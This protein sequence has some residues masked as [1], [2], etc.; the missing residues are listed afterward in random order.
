MAQAFK[1][2]RAAHTPQGALAW[3]V[4]LLTVPFLALPAHALFGQSRHARAVLARRRSDERAAEDLVPLVEGG[5]PSSRAP[6]GE[7]GEL[8]ALSTLAGVPALKGNGAALLVDGA[9]SFEAIF[10]AVEEARDYVLLSFYILRD[11]ALG[12]EFR[13]RLV[14]RAAAGVRIFLLYD[15][16]GSLA[17][18]RR[19]LASLREA[20]VAVAD[21]DAGRR[22]ERLLQ[23]NFRNHRKI[24][25]ADGRV[26]FTGGLNVGDE[27]MG[28]DP[29]FGRWRDTMIRLE[30]P[31]VLQLQRVFAADWRWATGRLPELAWAEPQAA[32]TAEALILAPGPADPL[33]TGSLHFTHAIHAARRR[34]W[35]ATPYLVPERDVLTAL[36]L[37]VLRGVDVRLLMAGRRDHWMVWLA[38]FSY[39]DE[40]REAGIGVW[41]HAD[42]FMHQKVVLVDD[43]LASVGTVNLD[44]R[45]CRLNFEVTATVRNKAFAAEVEAMLE[46]DFRASE[47]NET[48]LDEMDLLRR[49][50]APVARLFA[51]LL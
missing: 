23:L 33:E 29:R 22:L 14:A 15:R 48:P 20:G 9:A 32:G 8:R 2:V 34:L 37:A 19:Y 47:R 35:I 40:L 25:V 27:Y 26:G 24:V 42:G 18:P 3:V 38:G 6:G 36:K 10:R 43:W 39:L 49:V 13:D 12:R 17:L 44:V 28:R 4:F 1:A 41:R 50:G 21:F 45:S 46:T 30:G 5:G 51:P 7:P 16:V 31:V 11:D